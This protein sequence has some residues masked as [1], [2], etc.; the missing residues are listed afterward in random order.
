MFAVQLN[1][2][3]KRGPSREL[4][5]ISANSSCSLSSLGADWR[6]APDLLAGR[7]AEQKEKASSWRKTTILIKSETKE[8]ACPP[9][10]H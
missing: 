4:F 6:I 2:T 3:R 7:K 9:E 5:V 10:A 1:R 8:K